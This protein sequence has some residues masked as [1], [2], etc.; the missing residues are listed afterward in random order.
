ML[1]VLGMQ[2]IGYKHHHVP[3]RHP[4]LGEK[5]LYDTVSKSYRQFINLCAA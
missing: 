4:A 5:N 3:L 2:S 1:R